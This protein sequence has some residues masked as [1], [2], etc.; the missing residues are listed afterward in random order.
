[1]PFPSQLPCAKVP[2][3]SAKWG[4]E[5]GKCTGPGSGLAGKIGAVNRGFIVRTE[6]DK[7]VGEIIR[8]Q[9]EA[10]GLS[11]GRAA[12]AAKVDARWLSRLE[13]GDYKSPDA[14]SL[15]RVT[16]VLELETTDVFEAAHFS[17]GLPTFAP[18][19]R[20]RYDLPAEAI[21]QL[22]AHFELL[23]Q[24]YHGGNGG[25]SERRHQEAP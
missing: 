17:D 14:R 16:K 22:E 9:R 13:R 21:A 7:S 1:V 3:L 8:E 12:S 19:L 2:K 24:K 11:I 15:Y 25:R 20:S 6:S 18:Y 4:P 5:L 23:N 10:K